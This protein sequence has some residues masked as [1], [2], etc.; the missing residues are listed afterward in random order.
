MDGTGSFYCL[1]PLFKRSSSVVNRESLR[2]PIV[3]FV[4]LIDEDDVE[5]PI[6][7]R[8]RKLKLE[9]L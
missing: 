9:C 6:K 4:M 2:T 8:E 7:L 1:P 5:C 3:K